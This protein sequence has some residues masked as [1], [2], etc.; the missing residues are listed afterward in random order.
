MKRANV[1]WVS[2]DSLRSDFLQ[3]YEPGGNRHTFI[4]ELAERGCVFE[5][6]FPGGNWTMPSHATMLTGLEATSHMIWSWMHRLEEGTKTAFDHFHQAGYSTGCFSI[7]QLGS[8]F[9]GSAVEHSGKTADPGL[10]KAIS[11][12]N[13]FF[14]F[15]HTYNVH[16]P[17]GMVAPRDYNDAMSDYD[18]PS[19]T[20]NYIRHLVVNG[21]QEIVFDS[22]RRE[23]QNA[24]KF[25]RIIAEKL[26]SLG[27]LD[28]TY[29]IITADHGE[30]WLPYTSFHCNFTEEV[31]RVPLIISGP[32]IKPGRVIRP[33]SQVDLLPTVLE[34]CDIDAGEWGERFDGESVVALMACSDG[35]ERPLVIAGPDGVRNRHR[36][37]AVRQGDWMLISSI[38]YW[39]ESFHRVN[40][41]ER[42]ENLLD[43]ELTADGRRALEEFRAVAQRHAERLLTKKDNIVKLSKVTEKKL[44][45]FGYV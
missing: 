26:K 12:D 2:I 22:Y 36:Y 7:P 24:A 35:L 39:R 34:L 45:A 11:G 30:A 27:K 42:S 6:A 31:I 9:S 8:L 19:R 25:I 32:G 40:G 5:N 1:F 33:L 10:L 21:R 44:Q 20:L 23:I 37:L 3:T 16:Y 29:F 18:H 4:D 15:W 17:Y 14:V 28:N 43:K 41:G 13:P 38:G